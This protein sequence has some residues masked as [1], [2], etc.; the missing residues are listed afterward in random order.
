MPTVSDTAYP[1]LKA[2]PTEQELEAIYPLPWK[3]SSW[4]SNPLKAKWRMSAS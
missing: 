2:N 1:R 3:K 4:L